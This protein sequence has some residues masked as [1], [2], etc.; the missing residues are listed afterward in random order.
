M[1]IDTFINDSDTERKK[2]IIDVSAGTLMLDSCSL[3]FPRKTNSYNCVNG[4]YVHNMRTEYPTVEYSGAVTVNCDDGVAL[5]LEGRFTEIEYCNS[6]DSD[7]FDIVSMN[8]DKKGTAIEAIGVM[9]AYIRGSGG[10]VNYI[11]QGGITIDGFDTGIRYLNSEKY[12]SEYVPTENAREIKNCNVAIEIGNGIQ[13]GD[14]KFY[15][16]PQ[17][18]LKNNIY[19]VKFN[20]IDGNKLTLGSGYN[21]SGLKDRKLL[22]DFKNETVM[23]GMISIANLKSSDSTINLAFENVP[24]Q[25]IDNVFTLADNPNAENHTVSNII[26]KFNVPSSWTL[27]GSDDKHIRLKKN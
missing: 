11:K 19:D 4:I 20:N 6:S 25:T 14:A 24:D 3:T 1:A 8:A 2:Y 21:T 9:H 15:S 12:F 16:V 26:S 13:N 27:E 5:T 18:M 17:N 10:Y 7:T 23:K 22:I